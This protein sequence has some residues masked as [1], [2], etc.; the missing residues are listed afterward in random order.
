MTDH[1]DE[2]SKSLAEESLPRRESLRRIGT[3]LAGAVLSPLG[4]ESA[5][6]RGP[7]P[8]KAFCGQCSNK[9]ER[10]R[11][12]DACRNCNKDTSR[13]CGSCWSGFA[14]TDLANDARHCGACFHNCWSGARANE[15][16]A[17]MSGVCVYACVAGAVDCGETC[18]YLGW[19]PDNCGGCGNVCPDSAPF[20]NAGACSECAAGMTLCGDSCVDLAYDAA[21]C[22]ACGNVCDAWTPVCDLGTCIACPDGWDDCGGYCSDLRDDYNCGACGYSCVPG[23]FCVS[24]RCIADA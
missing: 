23:G 5:F 10:N 21:N 14:C 1:W 19:D 12:L 18:T 17:C 20:C 4:L 2:F 9:W 8:C 7:D 15:Q 16:T 24:G 11:C 13:L 3:V 22:G 6:A